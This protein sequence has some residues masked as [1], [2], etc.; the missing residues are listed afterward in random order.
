MDMLAYDKLVRIT[1][2][3]EA[4]AAAMGRAQN[5][6]PVVPLSQY[7]EL[8]D[9]YN[10]LVQTYN[11]LARRFDALK[12]DRDVCN[13]AADDFKAWGLEMRD[14]KREIQAQRDKAEADRDVWQKRAR[15][16]ARKYE[17]LCVDGKQWADM[18]KA[19]AEAA[20]KELADLKSATKPVSPN[21][22]A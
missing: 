6:G 9:M 21:K 12:E 2:A 3:T 15:A 19:R 4:A 10:E 16:V 5:Q 1:K 17:D 14:L 20:E 7:N 11:S 18:W 8:A 13:K 22:A